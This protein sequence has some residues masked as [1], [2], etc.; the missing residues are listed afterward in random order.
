MRSL[1][2]WAVF[3]YAGKQNVGKVQLL[4]LS[5]TVVNFEWKFKINLKFSSVSIVN[6][7]HVIAGWDAERALVGEQFLKAIHHNFFS[8]VVLL[9]C[10]S[11]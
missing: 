5:T 7:E 4:L 10:Y 6:F 11:E 9:S 3:L 1:E 2:Q 8:D